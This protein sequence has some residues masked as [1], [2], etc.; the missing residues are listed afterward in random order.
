MISRRT[1]LGGLAAAALSGCGGGR[2]TRPSIAQS[3]Q[4]P[5]VPAPTNGLDAVIDISHL[6]EVSDFTLVRQHSNIRGVFHKA[7]EGGDWSDAAYAVRKPQAEAAGLLWGAYHFGTHQYSGEDQAAAFLAAA[8]PGPATLMALDFEP[9]DRHPSNTMTVAQAEAFVRTVQSS[10][11]RLPLVY[12]H[13]TWANG[14]YYG[15][16][17]LSLGEA[18]SP[19]SILA[20]CDLWLADYNFE[21]EMPWAWGKKSWRFWQYAGNDDADN[22]AYGSA[23][24]S[25]AGVDH[26][27]RN[28][29]AGDVAALY[30]YWDPNAPTS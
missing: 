10:T 12:T 19:N 22:A 21:P 25:V 16:A 13:P 30:R 5:P 7:S 24:R 20:R 23:P 9:N 8:Q 29:F 11:G 26:C 28:L 15:H 14:G 18:I 27:D 17:G 3:T 1:V 2:Q 4:A 6:V